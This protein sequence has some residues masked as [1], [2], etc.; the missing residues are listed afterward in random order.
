MKGAHEAIPDGDGKQVFDIRG[1]G[2]IRYL[3]SASGKAE[4]GGLS[5]SDAL[6]TCDGDA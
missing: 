1:L 5:V 2:L 4:F 3:A 6:A